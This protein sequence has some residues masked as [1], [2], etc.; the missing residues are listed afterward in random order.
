VWTAAETVACAIGLSAPT[1]LVDGELEKRMYDALVGAAQ[2]L[3]IE[4]G[5]DEVPP[6]ARDLVWGVTH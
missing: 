6:V 2:R 1:Y 5:A 3:S 4:L